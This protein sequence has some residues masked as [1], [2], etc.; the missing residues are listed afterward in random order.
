MYKLQFDPDLCRACE[1]V[2]CLMKCQY[3]D[4]QNL[5]PPLS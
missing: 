3:D 5:S 1:T 2:D 4:F